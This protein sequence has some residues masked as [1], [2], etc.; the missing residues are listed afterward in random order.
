MVNELGIT[1]DDIEQWTK[2]AVKEIAEKYVRGHKEKL[3]DIASRA[4][5]STTYEVRKQVVDKLVQE[6]VPK[7]KLSMD[8]PSDIT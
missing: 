3:T 8:A 4:A 2:D 1:K 5:R 7:I 6:M